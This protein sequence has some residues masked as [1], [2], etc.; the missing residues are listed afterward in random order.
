VVGFVPGAPG[1][2]VFHNPYLGSQPPATGDHN[3]S[4]PIVM[5][6]A[7]EGELPSATEPTLSQ[8]SADLFSVARNAF[9]QR[10]YEDA[11]AFSE[12]A[13]Q[14]TPTDAVLHEFRALCLLALGRYD[15]AAQVLYTVLAAGPGWD[16]QTMRS[17]Y[18][19]PGAYA[20]HLWALEVY[21]KRH[22][23]SAPANFVLAYHYLCLGELQAAATRLQVVAALK[24]DDTVSAALLKSVTVSS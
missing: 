23:G 11:L 13:I 16:W 20:K 3:Y 14:A 18:G 9:K 8:A 15:E 17:F 1:A 12:A 7:L 2:L 10:K 19:D 21:V 24:P 6:N 22:P 4:E 5:P